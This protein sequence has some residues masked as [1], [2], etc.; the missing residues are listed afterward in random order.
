[1]RSALDRYLDS[2]PDGLASFPRVQVK[3]QVLDEQVEWLESL[4]GR[5]DP[6]LAAALR[7]YSFVGRTHE[8]VPEVINNA[9]SVSVRD[10][11][12]GATDAARDRAYFRALYDRQREVYRRPL[13]R[14]L[15]MVLSPTLLT[16]GAGDRWKAYRNGTELAVD[17]WKRG[18]E[19]NST[20]GSLTYP[21]GLYDP[22]M[23]SG[24]CEVLRAAIDAAGA[25][26]SSVTVVDAETRPGHARFAL[27]YR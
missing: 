17:R 26:D 20:T 3:G 4:D 25:K 24:V 10:R 6:R 27:V 16:L 14:A 2:L 15:L 9:V 11:L 13:Y 18:V 1:M 21:P 23:V 19:T 12:G 5:L 8:W 22:L 7:K